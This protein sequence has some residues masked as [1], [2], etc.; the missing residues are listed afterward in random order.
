MEANKAKK[1]QKQTEQRRNISVKHFC[2]ISAKRQHV[3]LRCSVRSATFDSESNQSLGSVAEVR[4]VIVGVTAVT[5]GGV[6]GDPEVVKA[7]QEDQEAYDDDRDG[8]V[9]I[10]G[11]KQNK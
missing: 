11:A 3:G 7:G 5:L 4:D 2:N 6:V 9:G 10:L 1:K 8:A